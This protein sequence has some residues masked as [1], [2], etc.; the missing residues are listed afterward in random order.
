MNKFLILA[1]A[2][3]GLVACSDQD[4]GGEEESD[5]LEQ[6][7]GL[8][9]SVSVKSGKDGGADAGRVDGGADASTR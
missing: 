4:V 3:G 5:A 9:G 1:L 6:S 2:L 7:T 8:D